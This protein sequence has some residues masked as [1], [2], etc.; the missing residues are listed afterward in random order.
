MSFDSTK[1]ETE[2]DIRRLESRVVQSVNFDGEPVQIDGP[3]DFTWMRGRGKPSMNHYRVEGEANGKPYCFIAIAYEKTPNTYPGEVSPA[4]KDHQ[5]Y[6]LLKNA[7]ISVPQ[8]TYFE[9][10]SPNLLFTEFIPGKTYGRKLE[11]ADEED[12]G[13]ILE[14]LVLKIQEFQEKLQR[15]VSENPDKYPEYLF[16]SRSIEYQA[17]DYFRK[18]FRD[19]RKTKGFVHEV[20]LP[21][22]REDLEG[23][24][25]VHGDLSHENII[26]KK[27]SGVVYFIDP[28]LKRR[29]SLADL[30][31]F[32]AYLGDYEDHWERIV[33]K[34]NEERFDRGKPIERT[35][36]SVWANNAHYSAR[37]MNK[38]AKDR[39]AGISR[40]NGYEDVTMQ[41]N[42]LLGVFFNMSEYPEK[43]GLSQSERQLARE[44]YLQLNSGLVVPNKSYRIDLEQDSSAVR[45]ESD[46]Y[47]KQS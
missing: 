47:N 37:I 28:E 43:F 9:Y 46:I 41:K 23:T 25:I 15:E 34:A 45:E 21:L 40:G 7:G 27:D 2:E 10:E 19:E 14:D 11:D 31:N 36:K 1:S 32:I 35:R 29:K 3:G 26:T 33:Q 39:D 18:I 20:Y 12:K 17:L 8:V 30:G 6:V 42:I 13:V 44:G 38:R 24:T 4:L 5:S 16:A 22:F